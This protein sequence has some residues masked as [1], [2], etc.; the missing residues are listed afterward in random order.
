MSRHQV[1]CLK[2]VDDREGEESP[3]PIIAKKYRRKKMIERK[4]TDKQVNEI[5]NWILENYFNIGYYTQI[6]YDLATGNIRCSLCN[7]YK[8]Y[9]YKDSEY[10]LF[11]QNYNGF[12]D[13]FTDW[14]CGGLDYEKDEDD[15]ELTD[16]DKSMIMD[17]VYSLFDEGI[18]IDVDPKKVCGCCKK[19]FLLHDSGFFKGDIWEDHYYVVDDDS[20]FSYI[21]RDCYNKYLNKKFF[22]SS[23][24][25]GR[26]FLVPQNS[27]NYVS[28]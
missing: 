16:D 12:G 7:D 24:E 28:M 26:E 27:P 22:W 18:V 6:Y 11:Y 15:K 10:P 19:P 20:E 25:E 8:F 23:D 2:N 3:L 1:D 13:M 5:Y 14:C 17:S 21:C 4:I 9:D